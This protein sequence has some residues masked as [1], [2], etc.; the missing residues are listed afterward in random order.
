MIEA[1]SETTSQALN[2]SIIG[3]LSNPSAVRKAQEELDKVVGTSRTPTFEDEKDLPY[4]RAIIKVPFPSHCAQK[5]TNR[6]SYA[7]VPLTNS[8]KTI[9]I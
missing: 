3:L 9:I 5:L 1:G 7:G 6:N 2:N 8:D 4:V